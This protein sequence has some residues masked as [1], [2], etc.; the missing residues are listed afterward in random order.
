MASGKGVSTTMASGKGVSTTTRVGAAAAADVAIAASEAL[1]VAA[2]ES[3]PGTGD[4]TARTTILEVEQH[5][6]AAFLHRGTRP[7]VRL[8]DD[9]VER[10]PALLD[11]VQDGFEIDDDD[12]DVEVS[13]P[14]APTSC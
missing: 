7:D 10:A 4:E 5:R 1:S 13:P 14:L 12:E 9:N 2:A 6:R 11:A 3:P 8:D